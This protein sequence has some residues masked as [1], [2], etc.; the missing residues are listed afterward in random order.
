MSGPTVDFFRAVLNSRQLLLTY[1]VGGENYSLF[2]WVGERVNNDSY[3]CEHAWIEEYISLKK[4]HAGPLALSE[5][6][7]TKHFL[8]Y[9]PCKD[10]R[11]AER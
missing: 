6:V 1:G 11:R 8:V 7:N 3:G 4:S 5:A 2:H 9:P 10:N